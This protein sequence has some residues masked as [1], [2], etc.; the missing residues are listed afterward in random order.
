MKKV[1]QPWGLAGMCRDAT[2]QVLSLTAHANNN[3]S[4]VN[5]QL[6]KEASVYVILNNCFWFSEIDAS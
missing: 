5:E 3:I 1:L 2:S 6:R 4:L